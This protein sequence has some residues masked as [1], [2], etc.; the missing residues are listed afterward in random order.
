M[1][2][3]VFISYSIKTL[4][5]SLDYVTSSVDLTLD[6]ASS[7]NCTNV[8]IIDDDISENIE[9]FLVSLTEED[10]GVE[11]DRDEATVQIM[12]NDSKYLYP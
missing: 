8:T 1:D 10:P 7:R 11:V 12:D 9:D 3:D 6:G 4:V 2:T 5:D